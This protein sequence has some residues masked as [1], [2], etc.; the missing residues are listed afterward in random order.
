MKNLL[1]STTV[2]R[3]LKRGEEFRTALVLFADGKYLRALLKECAKAF[4]GAEDGSRVAQ[5]IDEEGFSDCLF[6]PAEGGKL[7]VDDCAAISEES[8]LA[9]VEGD[10]KLFVLDNFQASAALVQ[11]KLLKILEEP[12]EGVYFLLGAESEFSV[13]PTVRSRVKKFEL[14][15]FSEES[16]EEA[17]LC[18]YPGR[19]AEVKQA[20]GACGGVYSLAESLLSGGDE[21]ALAREFLTLSDPE[22]FC[23]MMGERKDKKEFF[24]ALKSILRNMLFLSAGQGKY[25]S[26]RE[27]APLPAGAALGALRL[28]FKAETEMQFNVNFASC[29]YS[30][31]LGIKEEKKKWQR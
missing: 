18:A 28:V 5:L 14:A 31:A 26:A 1:R 25:A 16:V 27:E 29:L 13:L 7:T 12:P 24:S 8:L 15:P 23:R 3:A 19:A 17:L 2:Y 6:Y 21:F 22:R 9:P 10:K 11:N 30:L 4:F 20:A